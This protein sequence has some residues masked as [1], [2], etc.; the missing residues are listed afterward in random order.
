[1]TKAKAR[2]ASLILAG[3]LLAALP[4]VAAHA[5]QAGPDEP[6]AGTTFAINGAG[7]SFPFPLI[8]LWRVEY[9]K[10]YDNV[11]LNYQSIGSGGGIKQHIEKTV[12]F[13][14]SDKP[15]RA[16]EA[17]QAPGTMHIPETIGG[18]VVAYNLPGFREN[19]LRLTGEVIA[20]MFL[21]RIDRWNDG[22]IQELNPGVDLPDRAITTVQRADGSGTTFVFTDYLTAVSPAFDEEV[23]KGKSVP[24][25]TGRGA[26]GNEGVAGVVKT[27]DYSVGYIELAYAF[28]SGINYAH[29]QNG[30]GTSFVEPTLESLAAASAGLADSGLPAAEGDWSAVSMVNAPGP[31]SYPMATFTYLLLY[32][33]MDA[34]VDS[35]EEAKAVVHL[36]NWML[37]D[38]QEF[39][40]GLLYVPLPDGV[41]AIGQAGLQRATYGGESLWDAPA[42]GGPPPAGE[43]APGGAEPIPDWIKMTAGWWADGQVS[44]AEYINSLR[45]LISQGILR[46]D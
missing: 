8:D 37:T 16:S 25:P 17:G 19:G 2:T 32:E 44:D 26:A 23:G 29:V 12:S 36:I 9:G 10:A 33:E 41:V 18:V 43:S 38:G 13:A 11:N 22:R 5:Q 6:D 39:S 27:T 20:D 35:R 1:M 21:G 40:P 24:W 7:A 42:A 14:A 4:P 34:V 45:Y 46:V 31:D 3:A 28:K 30:D 15:L